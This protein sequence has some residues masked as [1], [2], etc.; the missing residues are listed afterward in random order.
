MSRQL[1]DKRIDKQWQIKKNDPLSHYVI[2]GDLKGTGKVANAG[3]RSFQ[4]VLHSL[5]SEW[6]TSNGDEVMYL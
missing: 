5:Y 1:Y 2:N 4:L 6:S 3:N